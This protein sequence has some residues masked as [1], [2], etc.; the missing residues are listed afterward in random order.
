MS[1]KGIFPVGLAGTELALSSAPTF[2][3]PLVP[4]PCVLLPQADGKCV[5]VPHALSEA[6]EAT[7]CNSSR[8]CVTA[9]PTSSKGG[10]LWVWPDPAPTRWIEAAGAAVPLPKQLEDDKLVPEKGR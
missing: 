4:H 7:A 6:S 8:S 5:K 2:L 9:Y 10:L 1:S 3:T